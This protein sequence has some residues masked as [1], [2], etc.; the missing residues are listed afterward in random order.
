VQIETQPVSG[1][2]CR[3]SNAAGEWT[4]PSTPGRVLV[5]RS[6]S[7]LGVVCR[8]DGYA[9]ADQNVPFSMS[10]A[11]LGNVM[12]GGPGL[13]GVAVDVASGAAYSYP[14]L[15]TITLEPAAGP[16]P[17][18]APALSPPSP[19]AEGTADGPL[20]PAT[21]VVEQDNM[22]PA[23]PNETRPSEPPPIG[24]ATVP[25]APPSTAAAENPNG[26]SES[27]Y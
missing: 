27:R 2:E 10:S 17:P 1:A 4:L 6:G 20:P 7:A 8:K 14:E 3:L 12:A 24:A 16:P 15:L 13:V 11:T 25:A 22:A 23:A 9:T 19:P 21:T 18:D 26:P 5:A